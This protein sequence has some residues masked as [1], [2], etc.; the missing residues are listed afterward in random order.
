[1]IFPFDETGIFQNSE[2]VGEFRICDPH[3]PVDDTDTEWLVP[4]KVK[5]GQP[6]RVCKRMMGPLFFSR[7][8]SSG[9][10]FESASNPPSRSSSS[11]TIAGMTLT[12]VFAR[13][14]LSL[15]HE[16]SVRTISNN[17]EMQTYLIITRS[18]C[19]NKI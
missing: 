10:F 11:W 2:M 14:D 6:E 15:Q 17:Y 5:N 13:R 19:F 4:D 16:V 1:M 18:C 9:I 7:S 3:K 8:V 12:G